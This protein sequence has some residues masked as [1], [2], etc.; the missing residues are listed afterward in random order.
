MKS[1]NQQRRGDKRNA[2]KKKGRVPDCEATPQRKNQR[3]HETRPVGPRIRVWKGQTQ[4]RQAGRLFFKESHQRP[5][6]DGVSLR[7]FSR[8]R[9]LANLTLR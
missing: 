3:F 5:E 6:A 8:S 9:E 4:T 1:G 7:L 2:A